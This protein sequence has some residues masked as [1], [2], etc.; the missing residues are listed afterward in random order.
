MKVNIASD[1]TLK[2]IWIHV[3]KRHLKILE[4]VPARMNDEAGFLGISKGLWCRVWFDTKNETHTLYTSTKKSKA[5]AQFEK[6]KNE[7][8]T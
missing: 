2:D 5:I 8:G 6:L 4:C 1:K 7:Y 3:K